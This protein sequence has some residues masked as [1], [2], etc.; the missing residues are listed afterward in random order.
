MELGSGV[1]FWCMA[2]LFIGGL[3]KGVAGLGLPLVTMPLLT[4]LVSLRAGVGIMVVSLIVS[5]LAQSFQGGMF[6]PTVRRFWPLLL[7]LFFFGAISTKALVAVPQETLYLF[8]GPSLI[9]VPLVAYL[10][11]DITVTGRAQRWLAPAVGAVA[12]FFGGISSFYGPLLMLY[13]VWLRLPMKAFVPAV[14]LMFFVGA[15]ALAFGL[16]GFGVTEPEELVV[17]AIG[18][19]PVFLGLWLGQKLRLGLDERRFARIVLAIYIATGLSF[20]AKGI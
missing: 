6:L 13:L 15:A 2:S 7:T 19:V 10:R 12:G 4:L 3:V 11:E 17:S 9:V 18:C 14:S 8:I 5:N 20:I 1:F 16:L